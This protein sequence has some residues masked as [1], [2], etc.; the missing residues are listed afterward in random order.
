MSLIGTLQGWLAQ[1]AAD[2][3]TKKLTAQRRLKLVELAETSGSIR[4]AG[5]PAGG[6]SMIVAVDPTFDGIEIRGKGIGKTIL[7]EN[8][9]DDLVV[10]I[11]RFAGTVKLSHMTVIGGLQ[12]VAAIAAGGE[13]KLRNLVPTFRLELDHV[14]GKA[15]TPGADGKRSFQGLSGYNVDVL[16]IDCVFDYVD[17]NEH[18]S[19]L[20]GAAKYGWAFI[21]CKFIGSAAEG[22]KI[23]SDSIDTVYAGKDVW[24]ILSQC[25]F[26]NWGGRGESWRGP[27]AGLVVQG[28]ACNVLVD[29]CVFRGGGALGQFQANERSH[30]A[31]FSS[32]GA[33][34]DIDTGEEGVGFGNGWIIVRDSAFFG[35]SDVPWHNDLLRVGRNG[36]SQFAAKGVLL[37][38]NGM[39]GRGVIVSIS[40]V[41]SG[42]VRITGCNTPEI[43]ARCREL[44]IDTSVEA[45]VHFGGRQHPVSRGFAW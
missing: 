2:S 45:G 1:R 27:G 5:W 35:T 37:K 43:A 30:C 23:R 16:A 38:S 3:T 29:R 15:G 11:G 12:K 44:G 24:L 7:N 42:K 33:S 17:A 34:F 20:R 36:G 9:W 8:S 28:G 21:R 4:V 32:E 14:H 31:M 18:S 22:C 41:P 26:E 6:A 13:N 19:Y 25:E 39:F 10:G 40:D